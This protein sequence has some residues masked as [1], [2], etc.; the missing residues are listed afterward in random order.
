MR[1]R[2]FIVLLLLVTLALS[3]SSLAESD[4][5]SNSES[6]SDSSAQPV[7]AEQTAIKVTPIKNLIIPPEQASFEINVKNLKGETQRYSIHSFVKGWTV[8]ASPV[9]I[10][11]APQESRTITVLARPLEELPPNL[12]YVDVVIQSDT[13]EEYIQ[14]LNVYLASDKVAEY[15]PSLKVA[16]D[17]DEIIDP[18][19]AVSIKLFVENRNPLDLSNLTIKLKSDIP[20]F[21][22]EVTINLPPL[23]KKTVE[24]SITPDKFQGPKEYTLFFVF[25]HEGQ[26]VRVIQKRIEIESLRPAFVLETKEE[27]VFLKIFTE[28]TVSNEGNVLNTQSV[29]LPVSVW[30]KFFTSGVESIEEEEQHYLVWEILLGPNESTTFSFVTN[31]RLII[32]VLLALLIFTGFYFYVQSPVSL[33]KKAVTTKSDEGGAL[34][35]ITVTL[36]VRNLKKKPLQNVSITDIVPAIA[37][38][39]KSLRLGTLRPHKISHGK[40]GTKVVWLLA[41]LDGHDHRIITYKIKAKLNILGTFSLPRAT[42]EYRKGRKKR[43]AY[44]NIFRL[45]T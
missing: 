29:K 34:S 25:E 10:E 3:L 5:E 39:E 6:D 8:T 35:E 7:K 4:S 44:S 32:Y 45:R 26:S 43:K 2:R 12:Y 21:V 41:E 42:I 18:R 24:L 11:L 17:M 33:R 40:H 19:E 14:R 37:N 28:V 15:L 13:H 38:V 16:L 1:W 22:K 30:R 23:E 36:D 9:I 27:A 31:Y 20:E